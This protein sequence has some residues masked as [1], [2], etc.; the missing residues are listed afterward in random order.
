[1]QA[2]EKGGRQRRD[3]TGEEATPTPAPRTHRGVR[4]G[5][6]RRKGRGGDGQEE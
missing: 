1:M 3:P 6:N 5:G 4:G 2:G